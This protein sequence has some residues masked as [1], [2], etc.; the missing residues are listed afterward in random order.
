MMMKAK[1]NATGTERDVTSFD[2]QTEAT[3]PDAKKG[4]PCFIFD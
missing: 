3:R 2:K 4:A 1:E